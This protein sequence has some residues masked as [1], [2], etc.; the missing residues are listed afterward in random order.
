MLSVEN[1]FYNPHENESK[2]LKKRK[3]ILNAQSD[4]LSLMKILDS[5]KYV[6]K[7]NG[8][9]Q[10]KQFCKDYYINEKSVLKAM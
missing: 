4:H 8:K 2:I 7:T 3:K 9:N 5:Y 6:A 10:A 1:V